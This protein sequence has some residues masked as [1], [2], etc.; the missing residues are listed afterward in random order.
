MALIGEELVMD[1]KSAADLASRMHAE[2]E[3][4]LNR[5]GT[6]QWHLSQNDTNGFLVESIGID[7][8]SFKESGILLSRARFL[9]HSLQPDSLPE[10]EGVM[11]IQNNGER[12]ASGIFTLLTSVEGYKIID[13]H[14]DPSDFDKYLEQFPPW[15]EGADQ[16]LEAARAVVPDLTREFC[17]LNAIDHDTRIFASKSIMHRTMPG[18]S[19]YC[20]EEGPPGPASNWTRALNTFAVRVTPEDTDQNKLRPGT[21]CG[22]VVVEMLNYIDLDFYLG[23]TFTNWIN[24]KILFQGI[25]QRLRDRVS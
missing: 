2:A 11:K 7:E 25:A 18:S 23:A 13:P 3:Q 21:P 1:A 6:H 15:I 14:S 17:V 24:V 19:P 22:P 20:K 16:K 12:C 10:R 4:I 5:E 8:G 9:L